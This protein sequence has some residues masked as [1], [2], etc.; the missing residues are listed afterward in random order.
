MKAK[1]T[2]PIAPA[3]PPMPVTEATTFL[4]NRLPAI[5]YILADQPWWAAVAKAINAIT[6]YMLWVCAANAMG[7]THKAQISIVVLR[8]LFSDQP[9]C[10]KRLASQP[11]KIL[12]TSETE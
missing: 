9:L 6:K 2:P 7:S 3:I 1:S 8:A 11:K 5:A 10:M 12:P 4:G